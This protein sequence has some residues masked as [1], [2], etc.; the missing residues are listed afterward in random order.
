MLTRRQVLTGTAAS[1][2]A[3]IAAAHGAAAAEGDGFSVGF[4][5]LQ[6]GAAMAF[7]K[8][9]LGFRFFFKT[10]LGAAEVFYKEEILGNIGLFLKFF[11]KAL[12][13]ENAFSKTEWQLVDSFPGFLK[14]ALGASAGFLK[15]DS[16][17]AQIFLKFENADQQL[18]QDVRT[19]EGGLLLPAVQSCDV[20]KLE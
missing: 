8:E 12:G 11:D 3:A 14:D 5:N 9:Q 16:A 19:L 17:V 1:S 10:D 20:V 4:G 6:D 18:V 13:G 7:H 15:A 2:I